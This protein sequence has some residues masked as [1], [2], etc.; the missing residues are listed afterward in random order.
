MIAFNG[1]EREEDVGF[2]AGL[3]ESLFSLV[4]MCTMMGWGWAADRYG[5]KPTLIWSN[6]G[7]AIVITLFGFSKNI[8]QMI[9]FRCMAGLFSGS[10]VSIR[11]MIS[12]NSTKKTQARA[13]S[14]WAA[15]GNVGIFIGPFIGGALANPATLYPSIFRGV[16]LFED[17]PYALATIVAGAFSASAAIVSAVF[18]K[19]TLPGKIS[20]QKVEPPMS[21]WQLLK[22][23][24]VAIV[25]VINNFCAAIGLGYTA[26]MP[27]FWYTSIRL[28]GYGFSPFQESIF[29][30]TFGV[31]QALW[32][33]IALPPFQRRFGTIGIF[34]FSWS[35]WPLLFLASVAGNY[36]LR[37]GHDTSFWVLSITSI[38][39]GSSI[40]MSYTGTQLALNDIAPTPQTLGTLNAVALTVVSGVRAVVPAVFGAIFASGVKYQI[41]DG[42]F[43]WLVLII[44]AITLRILAEWLPEKA[45]GLPEQRS[46]LDEEAHI[47]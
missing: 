27:V 39:L 17:Y 41:L 46:D 16:T 29:L 22:S 6:A 21:T 9:L 40:S 34:R 10:V 36:L 43:V 13:F 32:G 7:G 38:V 44:L 31:G 24:G 25:L 42:H 20:G 33:L 4:Q 18:L 19:E 30:A 2:Y 1:V 23:P 11:A 5:R 8:W 3:I 14:F 45:R 26:V 35:V 15:A 28:G 37:W 12:E 47:D